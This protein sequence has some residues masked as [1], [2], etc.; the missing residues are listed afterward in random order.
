MLVK[1][2][3]LEEPIIDR[4]IRT[5]VI[6]HVLV[7]DVDL[8]HEE[9]NPAYVNVYVHDG[10]NKLNLYDTI[11]ENEYFDDTTEYEGG[12]TEWDIM[13]Q[14]YKCSLSVIAEM[15]ERGSYVIDCLLED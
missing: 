10:Y 1:L 9:Y 5:D 3:R 13:N 12:E 6:S 2:S 14:L 4:M 8:S 11:I 7:L 15:N